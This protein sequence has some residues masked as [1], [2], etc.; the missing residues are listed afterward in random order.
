MSSGRGGCDPDPEH[1]SRDAVDA[2][3]RGA[4]EKQVVIHAPIPG[5]PPDMEHDMT[6]SPRR[7]RF[8]LTVALIPA[9]IA[10]SCLLAS[11]ASAD[12]PP[13]PLPFS[14]ATTATAAPV[15]VERDGARSIGPN[16]AEQRETGR[17]DQAV[18]DYW[19]DER[20][21]NAIPLDTPEADADAIA[22]L[23]RYAAQATAEP[24]PEQVTPSREAADGGV[25]TLATPV[26]A[27][28]R[29]NGKVF[30][31]DAST[32][33]TYVCSGAA[34][35]SSSLR[36]VATAGH[37]VHGGPGGTFHQ[38]W[39][40]VPGYDG[41]AR[42]FGTFTASQIRT[43]ND[44]ISYGST[45]R[46]L[47]SDVAFVT[48]NSNANGVR[49][50]DAVGGHGIATSGSE[51]AFDLR[52]FGYPANL[53]QGERQRGCAGAAATR[54]LDGYVF[55]S[56]SGCDFGGG[57][58]GGP[59]LKDYSTTTGKGTLKSVSSWGPAATTANINGPYFRDAVRTLFT[60]AN[61][62]G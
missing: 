26:A 25:S 13:T 40:F 57:A 31:R 30:F 14:D 38:N 22:E 12:A 15:Y 45:G 58:S 42:P 44:W 23:R 2:A 52:L 6:P 60:T 19:T 16:S 59:W 46:G 34:V 3:G 33:G 49:L 35:N 61:A 4:A 55:H 27:T 11:P 29:V 36:L 21:R 18:L 1:T 50:V 41:G 47:N 28:S 9:A 20:L 53:E 10:A 17:G 39:I 8:A 54:S 62:D 7:T 37:C 56:I 43:M 32:G 51:Y 24:T 48:T 5:A